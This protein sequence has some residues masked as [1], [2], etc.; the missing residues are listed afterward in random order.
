MRVSVRKSLLVASVELLL[1]TAAVAQPGVSLPTAPQGPGGEDTIETSSG[2]RC[3]QS[4]NS[5]QGYLDIG[6]TGSVRSGVPESQTAVPGSV[7]PSGIFVTLNDRDREALAYARITIPLGRQPKRLDCTR[8][9]ELE[10]ERLREEIAL[11]K[12]NAE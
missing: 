8:I 4:I 12:M 7:F 1:G 2:T 11:L 5:N 6:V 3:R 9:F 10:I